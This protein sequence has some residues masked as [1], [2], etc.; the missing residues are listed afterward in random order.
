MIIDSTA[1]LKPSPV[2]P[3]PTVIPGTEPIY[4][5]AGDVGNRTLWYCSSNPLPQLQLT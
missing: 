3:M 2:D 5:T 4:V 1:I